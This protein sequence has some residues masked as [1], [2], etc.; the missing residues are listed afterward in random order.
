LNPG[1]PYKE[2]QAMLVELQGSWLK[3]ATCS[4]VS[5][6]NIRTKW[7]IFVKQLL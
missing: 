7:N 2:E 5:L 6:Y 3:G 1:S 4:L